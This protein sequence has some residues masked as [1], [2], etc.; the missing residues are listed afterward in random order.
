MAFEALLLPGHISSHQHLHQNLLN[1]IISPKR[2]KRGL[3]ELL[4]SL[5]ERKGCGL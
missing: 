3:T 2:G 4:H 1:S 5:H